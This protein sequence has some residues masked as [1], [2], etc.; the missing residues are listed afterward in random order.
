MALL[1]TAGS[2]TAFGAEPFE[3]H[4]I[5]HRFTPNALTVPAGQLCEIVVINSSSETIEFESFKLNRERV[6]GP[7]ETITVHLPALSP[8]VYDFYDDFHQ[9]VP[10]GTIVAR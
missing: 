1:A 7:G 9:D 8:G 3:L 6:V 10:Q 4:F 5:D 2:N